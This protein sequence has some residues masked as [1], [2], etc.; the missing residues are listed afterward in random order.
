MRGPQ[1]ALGPAVG[2]SPA[3]AQMTT[4][5][6]NNA[7]NTPSRGPGRRFAAGNPGRPKGARHRATLAAEALLDGEAEALTRKA[8]DA[9]LGGDVAAL[10]LCLERLLPPRRDRPIHFNLPVLKTAADAATAMAVIAEAVADGQVTPTEA[11]ELATFVERFTKALEV[12][13]LERRLRVLEAM[14]AAQ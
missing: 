9:A 5:S 6:R 10:R 8:V 3:Y 12:G 4:P 7:S 2:L 11:M 13:D 14:A 1:G